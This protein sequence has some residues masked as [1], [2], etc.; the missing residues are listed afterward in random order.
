MKNLLLLLF[1]L[2]FAC[3]QASEPSSKPEYLQ[4]DTE[5]NLPFSEAV[6]VGDMLYLS[7]QI[8]NLPGTLELAEG[9][10]RPETRQTMKNIRAVLEAN[11][12][13]MDDIVKCTC[14]LASIN[15]WG[16]MSE[17]YI[18]FFPNHKP[19]RSAFAT[20]GLAMGARVEIECM[21]YVGE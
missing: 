18:S 15:E 14:M 16:A 1:L 13:S 2:A 17:E 9:G 6:K 5:S 7:G 4:T 20:T 12:A 10:I 11:G 8:G 21:A 19:A 3:N